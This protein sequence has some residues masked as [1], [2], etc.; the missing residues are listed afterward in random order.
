MGAETWG[1]YDEAVIGRTQN[2]EVHQRG[3]QVSSSGPTPARGERTH[4]A[5]MSMARTTYPH[6]P[7]TRAASRRFSRTARH[8]VRALGELIVDRGADPGEFVEFYRT[9]RRWSRGRHPLRQPDPSRRVYHVRDHESRRD[10]RFASQNG[11]AGM[12]GIRSRPGPL[13]SGHYGPS[14]D[15][16]A[17]EVN[18]L[19]TGVGRPAFRKYQKPWGRRIISPHLGDSLLLH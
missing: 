6:L 10:H 15:S 7:N 2:S 12:L 14:L 1:R 4:R 19:R 18:R 5:T 17:V 11:Q 3:L 13:R 16:V 8:Q 9:F